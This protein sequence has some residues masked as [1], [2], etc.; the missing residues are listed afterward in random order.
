VSTRTTES[1]EREV[2]RRHSACPRGWSGDEVVEQRL[3]VEDIERA[4]AV[5]TS[6][7]V[8]MRRRGT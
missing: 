2:E 4:V 5:E 3:H 7:K 1:V 8:E 6:R